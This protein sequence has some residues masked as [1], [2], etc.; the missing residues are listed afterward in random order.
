M[1]CLYLE[2]REDE[3]EERNEDGTARGGEGGVRF[4]DDQLDGAEIEY[5]D[6]DGQR[7]VHA[8]PHAEREHACAAVTRAWSSGGTEHRMAW[9]ESALCERTERWDQAPAARTYARTHTHVHV[10]S[11]APSVGTER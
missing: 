9:E 4:R 3:R 1:G 10:H 11:P 6:D 7:G 5:E 2:E 8:T